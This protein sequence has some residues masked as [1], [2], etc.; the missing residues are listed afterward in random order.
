MLDE[1]RKAMIAYA[2]KQYRKHKTLSV[3][4]LEGQRPD[5]EKHQVSRF[6]LVDGQFLSHKV[7]DKVT[8]YPLSVVV[9]IVMEPEAK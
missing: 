6:E 7:K 3:F 8:L 4:N 5:R 9:K 2:L 1:S